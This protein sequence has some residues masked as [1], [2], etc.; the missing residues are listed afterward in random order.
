MGAKPSS[1]DLC[2]IKD[3]GSDFSAIEGTGSLGVLVVAE[4]SGE[5]EARDGLPLRPYAPAGSVLERAFRRMGLDRKQFSLTNTLRCFPGHVVV[6][7]TN[8]GNAFRRW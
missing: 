6:E 2:P 7:A 5:M 3:H 4:A 8:V 1:C